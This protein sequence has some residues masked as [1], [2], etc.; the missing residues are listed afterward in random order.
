MKGS[1]GAIMFHGSKPDLSLLSGHHAGL[2]WIPGQRFNQI[3][4]SQHDW[5]ILVHMRVSHLNHDKCSSETDSNII[6]PVQRA[7]YS[8]TEE[9]AYVPHISSQTFIPFRPTFPES[10]NPLKGFI[11]LNTPPLQL[12]WS[13]V[14]L[15]CSGLQHQA[16]L[17][18]N[19]DLSVICVQPCHGLNRGS[20]KEP[21]PPLRARR[22]R[23]HTSRGGTLV[24]E[25]CCEVG[26]CFIKETLIIQQA[27]YVTTGLQLNEKLAHFSDS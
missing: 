26:S 4:K 3:G 18:L 16:F 7:Q 5:H 12:K 11:R 20:W 25:D 22:M 8:A 24:L 14:S 15:T 1:I 2:P 19:P 17:C 27:S 9:T 6:K 10:Q 21:E 23:K 13:F